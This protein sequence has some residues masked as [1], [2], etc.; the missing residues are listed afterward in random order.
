[1]ADFLKWMNNLF[2]DK[3]ARYFRDLVIFIL[4]YKAGEYIF[5]FLEGYD[6]F[7]RFFSHI[8]YGLSYLITF[9][10]V[11]LYALV[12]VSI[13]SDSDFVI[14][15][16]DTK[17]IQM[18]HGCTGLMQLFQVVFILL[19]FPMNPRLK[20]AW[21]PVSVSVI[22]VASIIHYLILIPVAY[23]SPG[24]FTVYHNII[25]RVVFYIIFFLNFV[26]WNNAAVR[27]KGKNH[28]NN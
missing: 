7:V 23:S 8:Y 17:A 4:L 27:M 1:M 2:R 11:K 5:N 18:M 14:T 12:Y 21:M 9:I 24:N 10:S 25:S 6:L 26:W 28:Q 16:N 22:I 20:L 19:L 3:T 15:I 13:S